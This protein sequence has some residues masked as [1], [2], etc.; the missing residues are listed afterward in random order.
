MAAQNVYLV[1]IDFSS[2]SDH[3]LDYALKLRREKKAKLVALHVVPTE[4]LST[5]IDA[6]FD[7]SSLLERDARAEFEKLAK[8]KRLAPAD[9]TFRVARGTNFGEVIARQAKKLGAAM[10]V[11]GSHGRTGFQRLLLGSVAEKTLRY[12]DCP[13]LIIKK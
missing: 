2:G 13:V 4:I 3:A 9:C 11:M 12:A 7:L 10:I 5:P 6:R 8:R 1:P